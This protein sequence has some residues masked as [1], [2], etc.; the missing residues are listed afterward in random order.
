MVLYDAFNTVF[1]V[2]LTVF[3]VKYRCLISNKVYAT[4]SCVNY[5]CTS[6]L[7]K[8]LSRWM[9]LRVGR[10]LSKNLEHID[11][12]FRRLEVQKL[13][14]NYLLTVYVTVMSCL[15]FY[16]ADWRSIWIDRLLNQLH[17][18]LKQTMENKQTNQPTDKQQQQKHTRKTFYKVDRENC[19]NCIIYLCTDCTWILIYVKLITFNRFHVF[20]KLHSILLLLMFY[21]HC[22]GMKFACLVFKEQKKKTT[23]KQQQ[24]EQT[25]ITNS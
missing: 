25:T 23:T 18:D 22:N 19:T 6:D 13:W 2:I 4:F 12:N 7:C 20:L 8:N 24:Q 11:C 5:M 10:I 16:H 14:S 9:F 21:E 15:L 17:I 3:L 1:N